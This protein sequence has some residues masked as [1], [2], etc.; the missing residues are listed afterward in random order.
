M[1]KVVFI[2][3][4]LVESSLEIDENEEYVI[5]FILKTKHI[6]NKLVA[7]LVCVLSTLVA[8]IDMQ[9]HTCIVCSNPLN[10][11]AFFKVEIF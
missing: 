5:I 6:Q 9:R 3:N 11:D 10:T 2:L 7:L 1:N 4:Q 8:L